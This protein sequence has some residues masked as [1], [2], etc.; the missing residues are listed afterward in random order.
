MCLPSPNPVKLCLGQKWPFDRI[1]QEF[2][3][4]RL[5]TLVMCSKTFSFQYTVA[6]LHLSLHQQISIATEEID[7]MLEKKVVNSS[8]PATV[9]P[10]NCRSVL[11]STIQKMD[12]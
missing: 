6:K 1:P 3:G 7:S 10:H 2:M 8:V 12:L 9:V 11:F 5:P 4:R